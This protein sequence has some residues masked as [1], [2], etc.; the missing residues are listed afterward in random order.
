MMTRKQWR[1]GSEPAKGNQKK[2]IAR[3]LGVFINTVQLSTPNAE[4]SNQN[5]AGTGTWDSSPENPRLLKST[6]PF[7]PVRRAFTKRTLV[8]NAST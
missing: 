4:A 3:E 6:W 7:V 8:G 1:S 5:A 2:R